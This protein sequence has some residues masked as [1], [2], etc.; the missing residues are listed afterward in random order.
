MVFGLVAASLVL[1][2]SIFAV[3]LEG[4]EWRDTL[5]SAVQ[6]AQDLCTETNGVCSCSEGCLYNCIRHFL[7]FCW[8][9]IH[10]TQLL[11][12]SA[13]SVSLFFN[14]SVYELLVVTSYIA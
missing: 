2:L 14:F 4:P 13:R 10:H 9:N 5:K 6:N 1:I 8:S 11:P 12:I 3:I 7:L